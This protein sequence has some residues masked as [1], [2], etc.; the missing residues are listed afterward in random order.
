MDGASRIRDGRDV[1]KFV[2]A[3][4]P[5][6]RADPL[7]YEIVITCMI[8][9][10]CGVDN[11]RAPC[12]VNDICSKGYPK[13]FVEETILDGNEYPIY[14]CRDNGQRVHLSGGKWWIIG[15]LCLT[16]LI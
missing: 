9:G 12:M 5:D 10:P 15:M 8:H 3:E 16:T 11:P 1:D 4:I 2:C 14:R 7:L 13:V 6:E